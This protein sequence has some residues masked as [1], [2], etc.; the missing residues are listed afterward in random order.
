MLRLSGA[1]EDHTQTP[2][3]SISEVFRGIIFSEVGHVFWVK[4][5]DSTTTSSRWWPR[6]PPRAPEPRACELLRCGLRAVPSNSLLC[7]HEAKHPATCDVQSIAAIRRQGLKTPIHIRRSAASRSLSAL[8][9]RAAAVRYGSGQASALN[10]TCAAPADNYLLIQVPRA[11]GATLSGGIISP[12]SVN[13]TDWR[14]NGSIALVASCTL[15]QSVDM[16]RGCPG[17][18]PGCHHAHLIDLALL[19]RGHLGATIGAGTLSHRCHAHIRCHAVS[20][21]VEQGHDLDR[22]QRGLLLQL[23]RTAARNF[24]LGHYERISKAVEEQ[25]ILCGSGCLISCVHARES[26]FVLMQS[27]QTC[28]QSWSGAG[29]GV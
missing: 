28:R 18:P 9:Q 26:V 7:P 12:E 22:E 17:A 11:I 14:C 4:Y 27:Q 23:E 25:V 21:Q 24:R 6:L 13:W 29:L 20:G 3:G 5:A 8:D 1:E 15:L 19:H 16:H 2:V 10:H